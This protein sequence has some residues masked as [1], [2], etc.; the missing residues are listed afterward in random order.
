MAIVGYQKK[1][2]TKRE[3]IQIDDFRG[4]L[5]VSDEG[6]YYCKEDP[7]G[8]D[9]DGLW[10]MPIRK[11][12]DGTDHLQKENEE[13]LLVE[14]DGII[15]DS[16]GY[17]DDRCI[18]FFT[19]EGE[20]VKYDRKT[21]KESRHK[22]EGN[23]A[24][25][26]PV[27]GN[28]LIISNLYGGL[29]RWNLDT[30]EWVVFAKDENAYN[31]QAATNGDFYF[32]SQTSEE[33]GGKEIRVYNVKTGEDSKFLS[34][35]QIDEACEKVAKGK[36]G[37]LEWNNMYKMFCQGDKLY[38]ELQLDWTK[39]KAYRMDYVIFGVNL[40][41]EAKLSL[42]K[43]LMDCIEQKS[44]AA[45]LKTEAMK[46]C[47]RVVWNSGCCEYMVE[48]KAIFILNSKDQVGCFDLAAGAFRQ[49]DQEDENYYLPYYD[50]NASEAYP[51][52][53]MEDNSMNFIPME[54]DDY[55]GE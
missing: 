36:G 46:G 23:I 24:S 53:I 19:Y 9:A 15:T 47:D 40:Q 54:L 50:Y 21:G 45:T 32:Y 44:N 34:E 28:N 42:E 31:E 11:N 10:R 26:E 29:Y 38:V 55:F 12:G 52:W 13:K 3:E 25:L 14:K 43:D 17:V 41:G 39:E 1:D 4:L 8:R 16:R 7:S 35:K 51:C 18:V 48:G 30:D 22:L 27:S 5:C 37:S 2:V 49:V 20:A 6:I 33:S